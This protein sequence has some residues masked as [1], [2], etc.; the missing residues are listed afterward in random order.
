MQMLEAGLVT[1]RAERPATVGIFFVAKTDG[2]LRMI[3]DTRAVNDFFDEPAHSRLPTPASWASVEIGLTD[4]IILSQ[5]DVD[6]A[7]YRCK[8]PPGVSDLFALPR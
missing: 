4:D 2:R 8:A 6:N 5:M 3:L 7:F 1:I